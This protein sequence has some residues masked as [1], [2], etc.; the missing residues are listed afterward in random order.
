LKEEWEEFL[1]D[2]DGDE[3]DDEELKEML[4]DNGAKLLGNVSAPELQFSNLV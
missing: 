1:A 2:F 3:L 4:E